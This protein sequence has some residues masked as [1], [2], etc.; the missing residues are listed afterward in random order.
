MALRPK[1]ICKY[2]GCNKLID[3]NGYC[4]KHQATARKQY[5]NKHKH[6]YN[7][8]WQKVRARFLKE[9]PLCKECFNK[10]RIEPAT[11]VDH[12]RP[13][14]GDEELF[15]MYDNYQALCKSCHDYKTSTQDGGFGNKGKNE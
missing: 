6:L 10:G 14:K 15:W 8:Q 7:Y 4:E 9:N 1:T 12:I 2:V 13:H 11:V 5:T 3:E